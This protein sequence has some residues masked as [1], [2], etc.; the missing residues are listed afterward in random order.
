MDKT[1]LLKP[2][3]KDM[4]GCRGNHVKWNRLKRLLDETDKALIFI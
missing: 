1:I 2:N 3:K 4:N